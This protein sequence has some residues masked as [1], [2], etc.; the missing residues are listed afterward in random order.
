MA[1]NEAKK[2]ATE[3]CTRKSPSYKFIESDSMMKLGERA[4]ESCLNEKG[5]YLNDQE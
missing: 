1:E 5:Y 3:Y 4:L 2:E